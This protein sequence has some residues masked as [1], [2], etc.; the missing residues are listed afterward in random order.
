MG[1]GFLIFRSLLLRLASCG[2]C[3]AVLVSCQENR[4]PDVEELSCSE[5]RG[6]WTLRQVRC[7][8]QLVVDVQPATFVFDEQGMVN[9]IQ[10]PPQC[11]SSL[12]WQFNVGQVTPTLDFL[13]Q[14][15][16]TCTSEGVATSSCSA[17]GNVCN[18]SL[19]FS[20]VSNSFTTCVI[21]G[22]EM[23]ISRTVS[24]IN[25]P[26]NLSYCS[27]GQLEEIKI[28]FG[29]DHGPLPDDEQ[30][31]GDNPLQAVIKVAQADPVNFGTL[32]LGMKR[33]RLVNIIN[34]GTEVA[35]Q[36]SARVQP[37]PFQF[38][39]G[40]YPGQG[41]DCGETLQ[42]QESCHLAIEFFPLQAQTF[43]GSLRIDFFNGRSIQQTRVEIVGTGSQALGSLAISHGPVYDFGL[44]E[45]G[46]SRSHLFELTN[47][48]GGRVTSIAGHLINEPFSYTGGQ[49]PGLGG[50]CVDALAPGQS[51]LIELSFTPLEEGNFNDRLGVSFYDGVNERQ[52]FRNIF[53]TGILATP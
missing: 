33:T 25:N 8:G 37:A 30:G 19:S 18:N 26:D 49:F 51:C 3:L 52:A 10:G 48:G 35:S 11:E 12:N 5:A 16:M 13:G 23:L 6:L 43:A 27:S 28:R 9:Q 32:A 4:L 2:F 20:G 47:G 39:G 31:A 45:V 41:G 7:D 50:T 22:E 53:A 17:Q 36:L 1:E 40:S 24:V 46:Q 34:Q 44:V 15:N 42:T 14:G 29:E 38:V 21:T